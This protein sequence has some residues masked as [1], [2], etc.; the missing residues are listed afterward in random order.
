[1][2]F[3]TYLFL[4][5]GLASLR[6]AKKIPPKSPNILLIMTDDQGYGDLGLTGNPYV[7]TPNL[8]QLAKESTRFTNFYVSPVCAPTRSS[9]MTG[10]FSLRT[11][12]YDTYNGGAMMATEEVTVAEL[13]GGQ[14]YQTAVF[15]KWHLGDAYPFRPNDQGFAESLIHHSGG[16][17]QVGDPEN[18]YRKD[19]SYFDPVLY[20]NGQKVKTS[21]YCSDVFTD[22]ALEFIQKDHDAPFMAYLAFNAPHT[23]LQVP[24]EWYDQ[25]SKLT[26]SEE[27]ASKLG[28]KLPAMNEREKE[29][30]RRVYAM[31]ANIDYNIGRLKAALQKKGIL[32]NTVIMFLSDNG[33]QHYRYNA[34]LRELKSDTYE[35]GVKSPFMV[36]YP[37]RFEPGAEIATV[38]AHID[39]LPTLAELAGVKVPTSLD[40]DGMSMVPLAEG[41]NEAAFMN[42]NI[43]EQWARMY[44][45]RYRN[46]SV[47][48]GYYKLLAA[49]ADYDASLSDFELYDTGKDPSEKNNIAA[50]KPE[51]VKQMKAELDAWFERE[52]VEKGNPHGQYMILD[53]AHEEMLVLTRN[54][55][56]GPPAIWG[57]DKLYA[58]WDVDIAKAG[59]YDVTMRF[60]ETAGK[61]G[62]VFVKHAPMQYSLDNNNTDAKSLTLKNVYLKAGKAPFEVFYQTGGSEVVLPFVVEVGAAVK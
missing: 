4:L 41:K 25:Y 27:E 42:R 55:A 13:L 44:P 54:D 2:K 16:I 58:Y 48:K 26:F 47:R 45:E 10:K 18:Y 22:A 57:D 32:D 36:R 23:P 37:A 60:Q 15:G 9:L 17:G 62:R 35:G 14:G 30:A 19:S 29:N 52:V 5:T 31:V 38:A 51:L 40:I 33:P 6:P 61:A 56:K 28:V 50:Q 12:I 11:G 1:M 53:P 43:Y 49:D 34:G 20:R 8:D 59:R 39:V 24:E 7:K 46:I 3:L 21:G